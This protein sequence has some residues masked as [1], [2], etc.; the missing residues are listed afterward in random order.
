[1]QSTA[2]VI[3][4]LVPLTKNIGNEKEIPMTFTANTDWSGSVNLI[5]FFSVAL[6]K[7]EKSFLQ[8]PSLLS[9]RKSTA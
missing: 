2:L 3:Y 8:I 7:F 1:M 4:Y 5:D 6:I 9:W